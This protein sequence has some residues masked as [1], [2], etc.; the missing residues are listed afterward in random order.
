MN[1]GHI[2]GQNGYA[3]GFVGKYHVGAE[4]DEKTSAEYG[5]HYIPK[6]CE[7]SDKVN[8]QFGE[9]EKRFRR[10]IMEKGFI[11][12]L[13]LLEQSAKEGKIFS[14]DFSVGTVIPYIIFI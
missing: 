14:P 13:N 9:N 8:Q 5:L 11:R 4:I 1:V 7:Y 10:L 2:L 3:T 6:N 12:V